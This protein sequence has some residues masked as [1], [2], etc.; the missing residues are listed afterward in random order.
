MGERATGRGRNILVVSGRRLIAEALRDELSTQPG[1][2]SCRVACTIR[3]AE[4]A[5][6]ASPPST[7]VI[8]LDEPGFGDTDHLTNLIGGNPATRRVGVY[9]TFTSPNAQMA[10]DLGITVLLPLSS[11][12]DHLVDSVLADRHQSSATAAVGLTS[13]ELARLNLLTSRELEVLNHI[14]QGR[15]V[16]VVA[17]LLGITAHTVETH[18]RRCFA[19]LGV[20][21]QAHA[22]ALAASAGMIDPS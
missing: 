4:E 3:A 18:K 1:V 21:Q 16:K 15:P 11:T 5:L 22:V 14:A 10:F 20:Q 19:K 13:Q 17:R 7:F 6:W 8:D 12:L 9:D 2:R